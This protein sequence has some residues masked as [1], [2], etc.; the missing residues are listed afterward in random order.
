MISGA[1][2]Y[3][4]AAHGPTPSPPKAS[5]S[6]APT[7]C[8]PSARAVSASPQPRATTRVGCSS[9]VT[10]PNAVLTVT[11]KAASDEP[12]AAE[13]PSAELSGSEPEL[14]LVTA[15]AAARRAAPGGAVGVNMYG[16]PDGWA[17]RTGGVGSGVREGSPKQRGIRPWSPPLPQCAG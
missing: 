17:G 4:P 13:L 1:S 11:G 14:Q 2:S 3:A 16:A 10:S 15:S 6:L 8:T 12:P 5:Q 9:T 7:G